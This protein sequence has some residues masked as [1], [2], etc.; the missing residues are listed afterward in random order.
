MPKMDSKAAKP[1]NKPGHPSIVHTSSGAS[2]ATE[3][4]NCAV[5]NKHVNEGVEC[6]ICEQWFHTTCAK[7]SKA[8]MQALE[9]NKSLHWYCEGC[10]KGTVSMWKKTEGK[11]G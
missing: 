3:K 7:M 4:E 5:C 1:D 9:E 6:E 8:A 2:S 10:T 11:P